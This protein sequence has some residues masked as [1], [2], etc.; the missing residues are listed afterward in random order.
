MPGIREIALRV[1]AVATVVVA[2]G[3]V[4][5]AAIEIAAA[6]DEAV[7]AE[8]AVAANEIRDAIPMRAFAAAPIPQRKRKAALPVHASRR[9]AVA[10][11]YGNCSGSWCGRQFVLMIGIAY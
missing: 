1:A 10:H 5:A 9:A 6:P 11:R 7:S 2:L 8:V 4:P 3:A